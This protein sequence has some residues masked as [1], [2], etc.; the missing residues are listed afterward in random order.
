[1]NVGC[2]HWQQLVIQPPTRHPKHIGCLKTESYR[3]QVKSA[4]E[5]HRIYHSQ[6]SWTTCVSSKSLHF[7]VC[8]L[9]AWR[10]YLCAA[11]GR[12]CF[13]HVPCWH[14]IS[15]HVVSVPGILTSTAHSFSSPLFNHF[16]PFGVMVRG[17]IWVKA[18]STS[19]RVANS[20]QGPIWAF[21]DLIQWRL[22][23]LKK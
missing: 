14:H 6:F 22:K 7:C 18:G 4:Q 23:S 21:G 17:R 2:S 3:D 5:P 13:P 8:G 16:I 15:F 20:P 19:G 10:S 1:M 12:P 11:L 9:A